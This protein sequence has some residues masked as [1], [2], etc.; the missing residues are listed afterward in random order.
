MAFY[1]TDKDG[2]LIKVAGN[3]GGGVT[4]DTDFNTSSSN[5]LQNKTIAEWVA[6]A[7]GDIQALY[8]EIQSLSSTNTSLS[9][10][11]ANIGNKMYPVGSIY[12]SFENTSPAGIAGLGGQ[13]ETLPEGYALWTTTSSITNENTS[14]VE[15]NES[16]AGS[17]RMLKSGLPDITG[18]FMA[19]CYGNG[20][21]SGAFASGTSNGNTLR[22]GSTGGYNFDWYD[23]YASR[24]SDRY[25]KSSIV[26][27]PAYKIYAWRRKTLNTIYG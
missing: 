3:F 26:Q 7:T 27:P 15:P 6:M 25:G 20:G 24:S 18:G 8:A 1:V 2:K 14:A 23:F 17:S 22:N 10:Q 5:P 12:L 16:N 19:Y 9:S 4:V 11:I 13:W 21:G